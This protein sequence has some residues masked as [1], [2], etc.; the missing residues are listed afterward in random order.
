[1]SRF[2]T[3]IIGGAS[4]IEPV[5]IHP[6]HLDS[7]KEFRPIGYSYNGHFVMYEKPGEYVSVPV[8]PQ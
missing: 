6:A 7:L 3:L 8:V 2:R 4:D 5:V 1:M